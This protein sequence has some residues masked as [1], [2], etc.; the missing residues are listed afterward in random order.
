[1]AS[2]V[3]VEFSGTTFAGAHPIPDAPP[4]SLAYAC[5]PGTPSCFGYTGEQ[6]P[7]REGGRGY[8]GVHGGRGAYAGVIMS[9]ACAPK[10]AQVQLRVRVHNV[11]ARERAH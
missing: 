6:V 7:R 8:A 10:R 1:M 5:D 3:K 11:N 4:G 2:I 9:H